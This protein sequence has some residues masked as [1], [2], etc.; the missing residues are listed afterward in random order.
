[1]KKRLI[2]V[3]AFQFYLIYLRTW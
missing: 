2:S 1:M 3:R